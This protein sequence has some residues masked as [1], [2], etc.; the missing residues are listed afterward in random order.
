MQH[1]KPSRAYLMIFALRPQ[2][3]CILF[4]SLIWKEVFNF[5]PWAAEWVKDIFFC[6]L[7]RNDIQHDRRVWKVAGSLQSTPPKIS[8]GGKQTH[9]E[10]T[11][12]ETQKKHE[13]GFILLFKKSKQCCLC[14]L[15]HLFGHSS[16]A[17]D[18]MNISVELIYRE[19][20]NNKEEAGSR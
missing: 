6:R 1:K 11:I 5:T 10:I 15:F 14:P 12:K 18:Q 13:S 19:I 7:G 16:R 8:S 17:W 2:K 3:H 4:W 9:W 20:C